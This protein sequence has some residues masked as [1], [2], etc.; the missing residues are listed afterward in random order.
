MKTQKMSLANIQ[1][2]LRRSEMRNIMAGSATL[3]CYSMP[4]GG[5]GSGTCKSGIV[6]GRIGC[7]CS[8]AGGSC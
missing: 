8:V 1:G 6:D 4:C 3:S 7:V 5:G 2:K